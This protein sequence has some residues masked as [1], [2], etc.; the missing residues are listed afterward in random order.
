MP[1]GGGHFEPSG[2]CCELIGKISVATIEIESPVVIVVSFVM[3]VVN[4]VVAVV[5]SVCRVVAF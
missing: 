4:S 3:D 1:T 5:S 2:D